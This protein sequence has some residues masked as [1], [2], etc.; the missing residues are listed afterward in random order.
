MSPSGAPTLLGLHVEAYA[1]VAA[2]VEEPVVG[3]R[4]DVEGQPALLSCRHRLHV[5]QHQ[6]WFSE[7]KHTT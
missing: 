1:Q 7:G 2:G 3:G 4:G 6:L 5:Q